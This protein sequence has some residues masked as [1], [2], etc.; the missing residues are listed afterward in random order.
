MASLYVYM[1][2]LVVGEYIQHKG[3]G[4]E[5]I[6]DDSW[7]DR[8]S[9]IPLSLSLPI[10]QKHHKGET[11]YNYFDNLLPDNIDLRNRIQ[12]RFG[13]TTNQAFD[14]LSYIGADCVGA[15]Q[16]LTEPQPSNV[17]IIE[18]EPVT[19]KAIADTLRNIRTKPLGMSDNSNFRISIAGAQEKTAFLRLNGKWHRPLNTTPTTHIFKLPIGKLEHSGIDLS[20]S[21]EN[22][23][24]CLKIMNAFGLDV[25]T[26]EMKTFEEVKVLIVE[27]F[28]RKWN[29]DDKWIIRLPQE[30]MCQINGISSTLKYESDGGPGIEMIMNCLKSSSNPH[31]DRFSFMKAVYLYW[32]LGAIDGHAKNFSVFLKAGGRFNLTPF[33]D[34]LSAYPLAE[35]RQIELKKIKMAMALRSKNTHYHW[36]NIMDRYWFSQAKKVYFPESLMTQIIEEVRDTKTKVMDT[37][38]NKL[39]KGF[40]TQISSPIMERIVR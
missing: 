9:A 38:F 24:L 36:H 30:D 29:H 17:K 14:L 25:P 1:N 40:P 10:T 39:P 7:S 35:K 21:V 20:D 18:S 37:V 23:W 2:G 28:D 13:A 15:I 26:A 16:L 4:Q 32:V 11:V 3:G 27:R 31:K 8:R 12:A 5:F 22:E 33:Y 19:S 34:V 6:Y